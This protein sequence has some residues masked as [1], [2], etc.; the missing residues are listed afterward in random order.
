MC[1]SNTPI[2]L[3]IFYIDFVDLCKGLGYLHHCGILH[4]DIKTNNILLSNDYDAVTGSQEYVF[5]LLLTLKLIH[6]L[7]TR[8]LIS[9]F[10]TSSNILT[11]T[12]IKRTGN[13]GTVVCILFL[14][15]VLLYVIGISCTRAY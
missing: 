8:L 6:S 2:K 7:R 14:L 10:G 9:D 12:P 11:G 5:L 3:L 13:T 4:R 15:A 1:D